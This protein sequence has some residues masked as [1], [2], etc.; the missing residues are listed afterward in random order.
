MPI[1]SKSWSKKDKYQ[2]KAKFIL[3]PEKVA[4]KVSHVF[5]SDNPRARYYVTISAYAG[6]VMACLFPAFYWYRKE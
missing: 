6:A 3:V 1:I 5:V 2:Q 4:E